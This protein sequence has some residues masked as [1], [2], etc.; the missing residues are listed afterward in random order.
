MAKSILVNTPTSTTESQST[1]TMTSTS[2][3]STSTQSTATITEAA[4]STSTAK[5]STSTLSTA[6]MTHSTSSHSPQNCTCPNGCII[7]YTSTINSTEE[8]D[9][10]IAEIKNRMRVKKS[11]LSS[12]IRK[13]ISADGPRP[14]AKTFGYIGVIIIVLVLGGIVALDSP[15]LLA[16][17][18]RIGVNVLNL[19]KE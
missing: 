3:K 4:S 11:T 1:S 8:L 13:R 16:E 15:L 12:T 6:T 9:A 2:M 18:K 10:I 14:S 5:E 19:I 17:L 7:R